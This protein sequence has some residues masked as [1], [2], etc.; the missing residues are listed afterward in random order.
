MEDT[1]GFPGLTIWMTGLPC[2]GKST[3]A[4][5]FRQKLEENGYPCEWLDGDAVRQAIGKELGFS[6]EDRME[7][8]R[9]MV[10]L[11]GM[12]NRHGVH[13]I[14]SVIS[15]YRE[16]REYARAALPR[17]MEVFV[18]CPLSECERRDV[19]GMYARARSGEISGFTG[20]SD[21]Y[22]PPLSPEVIIRTDRVRLDD[23]VAVIMDDFHMR[24]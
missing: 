8:I 3:T 4:H 10:Y 1:S 21:P 22:E 20:I 17:F 6:K 19:K 12:L 14:V 16:M 15:P 2:S 24:V 18:D 7:N 11:C 5:A 9:R 13:T 23:N